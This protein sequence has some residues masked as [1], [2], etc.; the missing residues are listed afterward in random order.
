MEEALSVKRASFI[1]PGP[2]LKTQTI[3]QQVFKS[4][5]PVRP[6]ERKSRETSRKSLILHDC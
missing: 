3:G 4:V 2:I 5:Q 6:N 1:R